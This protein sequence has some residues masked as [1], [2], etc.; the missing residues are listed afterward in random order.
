MIW[1]SNKVSY[2]YAQPDYSI[3]GICPVQLIDLYISKL[4]K[5]PKA[6]YMQPMQ[7][8]DSDPTRPWYQVTPVGVNTLKNMMAKMS[9]LA[10]LG[11]RYTNHSLRAT[12]CTMQAFQKK[13]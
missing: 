12:A 6:F 4:P 1:F 8:I 3:P 7:R 11:N 5:N 2:I 9:E 13:S 10:G